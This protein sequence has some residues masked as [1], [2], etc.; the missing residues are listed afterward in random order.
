MTGARRSGL[1]LV[2]IAVLAGLPYVM[3]G[4]VWDDHDLIL[5]RLV[6]LDGSGLAGLWGA[7]VG[8]GL[9][10]DTYFRP[11]ALTVL[12]IV[13]RLGIPAVHALAVGLHAGSAWLVHRLLGA[14]PAALLG[15]V[16]FAVHP[17]VSEVLGWASA[18]PDVLAV[19]LSLLAVTLLGR[20]A[21]AGGAVALLAVL[22]KESAFV[23]IPGLLWA[24]GAGRKAWLAAA[25]AVLAGLGWRGLAGVSAG[26]ALQMR[27][28]LAARA[29]VHGLGLLV[30]P[31]PMSAIRDLRTPDLMGLLAGLPVLAGL[32]M[33]LRSAP[34]R[35]GVLL[36]AMPLVIAMPTVLS[37]YLLGERY[38]YPAL[39]GVA[40][41]TQR[42]AGP[43]IKELAELPV[44]R[45]MAVVGLGSALLVHVLRGPAWS[46]DEAL[47]SAATRARP[48]DSSAWHMS[49]E[50][51]WRAARPLDAARAYEAAVATGHPYPG[52]RQKVVVMRVLGGD[53][54]G[55]LAWAEAGP[56]DGLT[57]DDLAWWAR[58][59][60][61]AGDPVRAAA[62]MAPLRTD[63]GWAGPPWVPALA[64]Q[65]ASSRRPS[66]GRD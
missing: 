43:G 2:L 12:A 16:V 22:S 8:Q 53:H 25:A 29:L 40:V 34:T 55:A 1:V 5:G 42:L 6:A 54:R 45:G 52:D 13:G 36:V 56:T 15:A 59:A 64:D 10:G 51:S 17:L 60:M 20:S 24:T 28:A 9:V 57:A 33:G 38:L 32:G 44:V 21:V 62:V 39:L 11:V 49:G 4:P 65:V 3:G 41:L 31:A 14:T 35:A 48:L 50:A 61:G 7:P 18:L 37:G 19:H 23:L 26:T 58:A 30:L 27:P 66:P 63:D 47:F 46:T